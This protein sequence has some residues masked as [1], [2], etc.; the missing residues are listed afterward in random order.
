MP[1][2]DAK[3][4]AGAD[5]RPRRSLY[6]RNPVSGGES[7]PPDCG[8]GDCVVW[9]EVICDLHAYAAE[10]LVQ[11]REEQYVL[12]YIRAHPGML[13]AFSLRLI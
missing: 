13:T 10:N 3:G 2:W 6:G 4:L 1:D 9:I 12:D 5:L 8:A 7:L 11:S